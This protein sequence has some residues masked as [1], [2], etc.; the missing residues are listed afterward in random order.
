MTGG[1]FLIKRVAASG[2]SAIGIERGRLI[3]DGEVVEA[4]YLDGT[5]VPPTGMSH[6]VVP[7]ES[8]FVLGD[9]RT[10][11][12]SRD[13]RV[14][15]AVPLAQV[16]GRASWIVW[17]PFRRTADGAWVWNVRRL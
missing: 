16:A 11:L 1:P 6:R 7:A 5:R 4:P 15:G 17:P 10:P 13:S 12:A 2:G 9:N 3:V 14:F 8:V